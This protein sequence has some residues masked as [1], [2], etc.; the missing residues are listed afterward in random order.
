MWTRYIFLIWY[1][2]PGY[3]AAVCEKTRGFIPDAMRLVEKY[4]QR[5]VLDGYLSTGTFPSHKMWKQT[6]NAAVRK[7]HE[8]AWWE[9]N[10]ED[11]ELFWFSLMHKTLLV[12]VRCRLY[13]GNEFMN[14]YHIMMIP[15]VRQTLSVSRPTSD[16]RLQIHAKASQLTIYKSMETYG[17]NQIRNCN[18]LIF[19]TYASILGISS[20]WARVICH[21]LHLRPDN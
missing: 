6:V 17:T 13:R 21:P 16:T 5:H 2:W 4:N 18:G 15:C 9:R 8:T 14:H 3:Y 12:I 7:F 10:A 11:E 20:T 19:V 1:S